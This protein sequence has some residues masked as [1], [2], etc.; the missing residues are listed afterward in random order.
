MGQEDKGR[1]LGINTSLDV[2]HVPVSPSVGSVNRFGKA[3]QGPRVRRPVHI[4]PTM[5]DVF[6]C[7]IEIKR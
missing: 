1:V 4:S 7:K 5:C 6:I 2:L 3:P